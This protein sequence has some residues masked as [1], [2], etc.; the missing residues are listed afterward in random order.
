MYLEKMLTCVVLLLYAISCAKASQ[1]FH[2]ELP[3]D[4]LALEGGGA[5]AISYIG[6]LMA[7]KENG[8]Y[9]DEQYKFSKIGGTSAGCFVALLVSL[10]IPPAKL[11]RLVYTD[12]VFQASIDFSLDL[13]SS[14][15]A[16]EKSS[17]HRWFNTIAKTFNFLL[18]ARDFV[19]LW[20]DYDSPGLSTETHLIQFINRAILPLS[21]HKNAFE[22]I[23]NI[24]FDDLYKKTGHELRC[25]ATQIDDKRVY[26]FSTDR[27]PNEKVIKGVYASMTFPGLFKPLDDGCGNMFV[28]GGLLYNFPVTMNDYGEDID[29][30]TLGISL[31][32]DPD[33]S[34]SLSPITT[35]AAILSPD[36][37]FKT[38]DTI[39]YFEAIYSIILYKERAIYSRQPHNIKRV[40]YLNSPLSTLDADIS[41]ARISMAIN[42]AYLNTMTF[43][44]RATK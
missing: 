30:R 37:K 1:A 20:L 18:K 31:N 21:P 17:A 14:K 41:T 9:K 34:Q 5:K 42:N 28:D 15:S 6:A 11:E 13:I 38:V 32:H 35:E 12:N 22:H 33:L 16:P 2:D 44:N 36:F 25:F 43:L 40:I 7:L 8:Y 4:S 29:L 24:T 10:D 23:Q 39:Y 3:F 19:D 27:T 26:E